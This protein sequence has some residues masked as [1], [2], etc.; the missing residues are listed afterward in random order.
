MNEPIETKVKHTEQTSA[1]LCSALFEEFD[2][3][4]PE[5]LI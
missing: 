4:I 1:G 2:L 3:D 5:E